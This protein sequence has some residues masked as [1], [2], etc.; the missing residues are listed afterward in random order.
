MQARTG[1]KRLLGPHSAFYSTMYREYDPALGRFHA[2]DPMAG[3]FATWTP[4]MYGYNDPV[5]ANDPNG[6][7]AVRRSVRKELEER[8][9]D[10]FMIASM[11][12]GGRH[13]MMLPERLG[14]WR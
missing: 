10:G 13:A 7:Q 3:S 14:A 9:H 2:I 5:N 1:R 6:A 12:P 4:Y 8:N 11:D